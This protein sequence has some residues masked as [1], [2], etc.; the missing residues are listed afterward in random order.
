M[1]NQKDNLAQGNRPEDFQVNENGELIV[2]NLQL[3]KALEDLS[4]E[5]LD[6]IA[7]GGHNI[8]CPCVPK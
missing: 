2:K 5:E 3:A 8:N 6:E 7:G 4:P 1:S